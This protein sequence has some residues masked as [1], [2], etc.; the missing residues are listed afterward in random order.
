MNQVIIHDGATVG[1]GSV[2]LNNV[3]SGTTVLGNP[4]KPI[5]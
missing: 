4:A 2:V 3:K 5:F 1:I